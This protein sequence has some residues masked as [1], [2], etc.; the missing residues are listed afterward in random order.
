MASTTKKYPLSTPDGIS[1]PLDVIRPNSFML[2][3]FTTVVSAE[4]TVPTGV[5]I[6]SIVATEDCVI[7]FGGAPVLPV[8][9][10][11]YT[12]SVSI[13]RDQRLTVSPTAST[14]K[15]IGETASGTLR[16]NFIDNWAALTLTTQQSRR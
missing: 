10:T 15:V 4:F 13:E 16:I 9:G 14:F 8:S 6:M 7:N 1:I 2:I 11:L 12:N 5:E 3:N